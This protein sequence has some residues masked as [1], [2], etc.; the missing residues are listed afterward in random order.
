MKQTIL[1]ISLTPLLFSGVVC[2]GQQMSNQR[3]DEQARN[4][5]P[6]MQQHQQQP[7]RYPPHLLDRPPVIIKLLQRKAVQ[8]RIRTYHT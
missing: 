8:D 6:Q 3:A 7:Q 5:R 4:D 2:A 1:I